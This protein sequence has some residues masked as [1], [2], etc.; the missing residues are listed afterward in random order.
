[1]TVIATLTVER[2]TGAFF[3]RARAY[4]IVVDGVV[5]GSVRCGREISLALPP[6]GHTVRAELD[7]TGSPDLPVHLGPGATVRLRV[8]PRGARHAMGK[9]YLRLTRVA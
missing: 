1:M 2:P 9:N 7:W 8:E 3:D 6:G 5:K 4:K